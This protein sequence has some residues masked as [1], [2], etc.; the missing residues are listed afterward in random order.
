ARAADGAAEISA[1]LDYGA[2][3][4]C[5][6]AAAFEA[7]VAGHLGYSPFRADALRRVIVRI[8]AS[9]RSIEGP[10]EWRNDT[11]GWAGERRV[12]SRTGDGAELVRARGFALA[13]QFQLLASVATVGAPAAPP[14]A[15]R[16]APPAP[17]APPIVRTAPAPPAAASRPPEAPAAS[18]RLRPVIA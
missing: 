17:P 4:G 11:G 3:P 6:D 2:V 5:P 16:P 9:D 1:A 8:E 13:V 12:P 18:S 14:D 7:V 15:S 10:V